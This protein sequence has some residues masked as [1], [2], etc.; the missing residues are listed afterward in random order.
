MP[1]ISIWL[2]MIWAKKVTTISG[3]VFRSE[4]G[5]MYLTA[6]YTIKSR[7]WWPRSRSFSKIF[8]WRFLF[9]LVNLALLNHIESFSWRGRVVQATKNKEESCSFL[10]AIGRRSCGPLS[11]LAKNKHLGK[12]KLRLKR[13]ETAGQHATVRFVTLLWLPEP[14]LHALQL[15]FESRL[16]SLPCM[17]IVGHATESEVHA[18]GKFCSISDPLPPPPPSLSLSLSL[19]VTRFEKKN[20]FRKTRQSWTSKHKVR[21]MCPPGPGLQGSNR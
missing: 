6:L 19:R 18:S 10:D 11:G 15:T 8:F 17:H 2:M 4:E 3:R 21:W 5:S 1:A 7:G 9:L 16:L 13:I 12:P 20:H 14:D